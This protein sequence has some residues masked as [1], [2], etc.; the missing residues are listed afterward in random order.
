MSLASPFLMSVFVTSERRQLVLLGRSPGDHGVGFPRQLSIRC[1]F[2]IWLLYLLLH[3]WLSCALICR[4]RGERLLLGYMA[5][6][7]LGIFT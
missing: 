7:I 3:C 6:Y 1:K 4:A 2:Q 5:E